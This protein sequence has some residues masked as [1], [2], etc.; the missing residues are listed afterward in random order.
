MKAADL[1]EMLESGELTTE[2]VCPV[3]FAMSILGQRWK[4][5]ILWH[6]AED[7]ALRY[8]EL[9]RGIPTITNIMLTQSLRALEKSKLVARKNLAT[10]PP[11][12]E[13]SLTKRGESLIPL[14]KQIHNWGQEQMEIVAGTRHE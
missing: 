1:T 8:N 5:P 7:G 14:L 12:V 6:L 4:V 11:H 10:V 3:L 13:Y 9:K 2:E